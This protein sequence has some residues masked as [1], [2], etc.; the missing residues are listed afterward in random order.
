[1]DN[2]GDGKYNT[3]SFSSS[4]VVMLD[5]KRSSA[6]VTQR[7][8]RPGHEQTEAR[9]NFQL[10]P[11]GNAFTA[12]S[13]NCVIS[14]HSWDG[15]LL[16]EASFQSQRFV[17]YRTWKSNFTAA[18]TRPVDVKAFMYGTDPQTSV[19][20]IY[21]SWNGATEVSYWR[22]YRVTE[23]ELAILGERKKTGFE[24]MFQ[25]VGFE[26]HVLVEAIAVDGIT[27]L[28]RSEVCQT[29][30]A[31]EAASRPGEDLSYHSHENDAH[32]LR[33]G[34]TDEQARTLLS[35]ESKAKDHGHYELPAHRS[36]L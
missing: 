28:G 9:G 22:F 4:L 34:H 26:R 11:N 12:W 2:G 31:G 6:N 24:T 3:S 19:T 27:A 16:M 10:L 15:E 23:G 18:P 33:D 17:T 35:S 32:N 20:A 29:V 36:E 8:I 30:V 14:E 1:M 25:T 7:W 5:K 21:V 13:E